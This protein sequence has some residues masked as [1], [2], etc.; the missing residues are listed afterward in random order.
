MIL[1]THY[2]EEIMPAFSHVFLLKSG[3]C[4]AQG[5]KDRILRRDLLT[6]AFGIPIEAGRENGRYWSRVAKI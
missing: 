5:E 1:V 4:A 3:R 2:L 6:Q